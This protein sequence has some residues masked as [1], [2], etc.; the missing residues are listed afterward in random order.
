MVDAVY[1]LSPPIVSI[2]IRAG[3]VM[4]GVKYKYLNRESYDDKYV[5]RCAS[6]LDQLKKFHLLLHPNTLI[7]LRSRTESKN[8]G[9]RKDKILAEFQ[10]TT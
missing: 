5:G 2:C 10:D 4:G 8:P 1:T 3:L 9:K 7:S 6:G